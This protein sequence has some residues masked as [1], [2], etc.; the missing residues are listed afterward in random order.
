MSSKRHSRQAKEDRTMVFKVQLQDKKNF[1]SQSSSLA[2]Q[3][4]FRHL[5]RGR[6]ARLE[7]PPRQQVSS[8]F[9]GHS[10]LREA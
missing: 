3:A 9:G 6:L 5:Y 8:Q 4:D 1:A 2:M 7:C 10:T